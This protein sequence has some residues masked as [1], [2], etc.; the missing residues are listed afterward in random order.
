MI[1]KLEGDVDEVMVDEL[2][3]AENECPSDEELVVYFS[4][5]GGSPQDLNVLVDIINE[6]EKISKVNAF[7]I[8][9]SAGFIFLMRVE[10]YVNIMDGCVGMAHRA[11]FPSSK[12]TDDL[13]VSKDIEEEM[14]HMSEAA[15][16]LTED[17]ISLNIFTKAEV[18]RIKEGDNVFFSAERLREMRE[19]IWQPLLKQYEE[20][21]EEWK[22]TVS[23][24]EDTLEYLLEKQEE[25]VS[26]IKQKLILNT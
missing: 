21:V 2:I 3:R 14:E 22:Q 7:G 20:A 1:V 17:T 26:K 16:K 9:Y 24:Q 11:Y 10:K 15:K 13:R 5:P 8:A 4:S 23:N 19:V 25:I 12:L 6:S 18:K